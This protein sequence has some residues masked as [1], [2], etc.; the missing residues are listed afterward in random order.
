MT[1]V[2][3]GGLLS[4]GAFVVLFGAAAVV[5]NAIG[6]TLSPADGRG[7]LIVLAIAA[8]FVGFNA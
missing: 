4:V 2:L 3:R 6:V 7:V 1:D 8:L 5:T